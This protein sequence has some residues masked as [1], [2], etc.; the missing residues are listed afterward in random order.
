MINGGATL[1][2]G[3]ETSL[4]V[5]WNEWVKAPAVVFTDFRYM[6]LPVAE[7]TNNAL[8]GGNRLPYAPKNT[9]SFLVGARQP[10]GFGM[11][12]DSSFVG[13]Q[14]GDN[15]NTF[16]PSFDGTVGRLP[17]FMLW[18]L[19]F[20]YTYQRERYQIKLYVA[21]KNLTNKIYISSR[22][23]QGVQLGMFQQVNVG[24]RFGF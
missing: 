17:G 3:F 9:F 5:N 6:H 19:G 4:R 12:L 2:Q 7:F 15:L 13:N 14:F 16:A 11:Q 10:Q 21:I 22:A 1:H 20:D 8:Y 24:I 18:N 23:P